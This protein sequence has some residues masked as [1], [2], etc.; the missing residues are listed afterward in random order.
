MEYRLRPSSTPFRSVILVGWSVQLLDRGIDVRTAVF[1]GLDIQPAAAIRSSR[2][3]RMMTP[4]MAKVEPSVWCPRQSTSPHSTSPSVQDATSS[5]R[6]S[7]TPAK[8]RRPVLKDLLPSRE[9]AARMCGLVA[10]IV[11]LKYDAKRSA[12]CEFCASMRRSRNRAH[13]VKPRTTWPCAPLGPTQ[14]LRGSRGTGRS[15]PSPQ[16]SHRR[17]SGGS[18]NVTTAWPMEE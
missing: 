17:G 2:I 10:P 3:V 7:G 5:A 18:R 15:I 11:V 4:R 13:D 14:F 12:S 16:G 8:D 6:K 1:D 9:G